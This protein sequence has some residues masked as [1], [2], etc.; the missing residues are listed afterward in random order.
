M[1]KYITI[2]LIITLAI[3]SSVNALSSFNNKELLEINNYEQKGSS[4]TNT[5]FAEECTATWCPNCPIAAEALHNIYESGDYSFYYVSLVD[6]MNTLAKNRNQEYSFGIVNVYAF[7]TV[8][9]DGGYTH[10]IGRGSNVVETESEYRALIEQAEQRTPRKPITME[11]SVIWNG[12]AKLTVTITITNQ[13]NS[14]YLGKIRSHVTE[15]ESRWV[16]DSG[17]PYHF[18]FLDY[19]LN[20]LIFLMPGE[21]KTLTGTFDGTS[22]HGGQTYSDITSDNIMVIS[23]ISNFVPHY[24]LGYQGDKYTQRYF[25]FYVDQT[26]AA[27][28][29]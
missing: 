13:G 14:L 27:T 18:G 21:S 6:D 8:Y 25:A 28:P 5:V 20:K 15:I 7:P 29:I 17:D 3:V 12:N 26:T 19:A 10:M 16:D 24:R 2:G 11:S 9:F 22:D 23:T 1:K 4:F